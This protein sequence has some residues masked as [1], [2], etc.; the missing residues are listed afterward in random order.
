VYWGPLR[1][2]FIMLGVILISFFVCI[3]GLKLEVDPYEKIPMYQQMEMKIRLVLGKEDEHIMES[4]E[5]VVIIAKLTNEETW[6]VR[7]LNDTVTFSY[8]DIRRSTKKSLIV[9]GNIIG[10]NELELWYKEELLQTDKIF[11]IMSDATLNQIFTMVMVVMVLVNTINMGAQLDLQIIKEVFKKPIGPFVGFV[12]QF[13]FMPL[14]SFLTGWLLSD[15]MLFRLGLFVLGCCPGGTGSNFWT[16]LLQGDINLSI[17]MT[18]LSTVLALGMMP[19][20]IFL[21]GPLLTDGTLK[22]PFGQLIFSLVTLILPTTLGMWVRW[23]WPKAAKFMEKIIVPFTLITVLFILT[24]GVY[25]NL[26]IFL[27]ITPLMILAGFIVAIAGYLFGAS[28]AWVFRL[29]LPQITAVAIETSFQNGGIAFILL[30]MSLEEPFGELAAVAPVAQLMITGLP[31]WLLLGCLKIY[32]K[33][34]KKDPKNDI[35]YS[36]VQR[37]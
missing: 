19:L 34:I 15:D 10:I 25:I 30:K 27:L 2:S 31:L 5:D 37:L 3:S 6:A 16:L 14:F 11:V 22:I 4:L 1:V 33:C 29:K 36:A 26:F 17:T 18:F 35:Q 9:Q 28:F 12:S 32:Q 8:K 21:M 23:K 7:L 13:L 24:A 20:W